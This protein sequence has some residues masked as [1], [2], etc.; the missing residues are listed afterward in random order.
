MLPGPNYQA[1][2]FCGV[3]KHIF[4]LIVKYDATTIKLCTAMTSI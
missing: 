2:E 1:M 4:H 3:H